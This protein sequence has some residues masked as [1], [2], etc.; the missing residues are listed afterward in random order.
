[1]PKRGWDVVEAASRS[2]EGVE[3]VVLQALFSMPK[4][5]AAD[6]R[7]YAGISL[8]NGDVRGVRPQ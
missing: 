3:P 5:E 8:S 6:G 7:T 1:M 2:R 4:P